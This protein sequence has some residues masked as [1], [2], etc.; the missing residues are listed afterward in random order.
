MDNL[1]DKEEANTKVLSIL[2][3]MGTMEKSELY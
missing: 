2:L 1:V 3:L